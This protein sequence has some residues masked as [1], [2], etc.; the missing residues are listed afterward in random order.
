MLFSISAVLEKES[1]TRFSFLT[2]LTQGSMGP[3]VP[4]SILI[5]HVKLLFFSE[6]SC[7]ENRWKP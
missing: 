1:G 6:S 3:T 2:V 7:Y 4:L 5:K